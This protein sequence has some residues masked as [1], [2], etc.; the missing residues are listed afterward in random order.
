MTKSGS[1]SSGAI[2]VL[3]VLYFF[4]GLEYLIGFFAAVVIHEL[5]HIVVIN[6]CGGNV[7]SISVNAFG[8]VID[9]YG[10]N[11]MHKELLSI[12]AG[13]AAGFALSYAASFF[14]NFY[15][16]KLLLT[17]AGISLLLSVYNILPIYPLD[18][19]RFVNALLKIKLSE[20]KAEQ[21]VRAI[22]LITSLT[23]TIFGLVSIKQNYGFA[24]LFAAICTFMVQTG[25]VK[26]QSVL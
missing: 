9:Y 6:L 1:F 2:L 10:I 22:G 12:A 24:L 11:E 17:T 23:M 18:G 15:S 4:G 13:P 14:G 3:S 7:R 26:K 19:G 5:G 21:T 20:G 8:A 16:N 25:I